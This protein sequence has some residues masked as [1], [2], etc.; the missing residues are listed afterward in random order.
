MVR[1]NAKVGEVDEF[2]KSDGDDSPLYVIP[3]LWEKE[4]EMVAMKKSAMLL[5]LMTLMVFSA[6]M[7]QAQPTGLVTCT[8]TAVPPVV[9]AEGIAE[10]VG[11]V[12]LAC[13][14]TNSAPFAPGVDFLVNISVS[15]NVNVTNNI[16]FGAGTNVSDAVLVINENNCTAPSSVGA[17]YTSCGAP[18]AQ[19]Q[20]PQFGVLAAN[21]RLEWNKTA[22]PVPGAARP[23][24][25][26]N[27]QVTTVRIT[28][29]RGN[30]SQLGVPDAATFPSTQI[31]AFVSIT[32]PTTISVTNN[33]LNVAVPILGL[34][35]TPGKIVTGLQCLDTTTA[36]S[37]KLTEGF[38]TAFKT[39][40]VPTYQPGN[41]QWE[42]G[43]YAPGSNNGGGASQGTRFLI[44]FF[45]IP[46]GVK[47]TVP[48]AINN[49]TA[50]LD[51]DALWIVQVAGADSNGAGGAMTSASDTLT[52]GLSGGF[53]SVTYEVIDDDPFRLESITI[54]IGVS[55]VADTTNDLPAIGTGQVSASF[56]PLSTIVVASN[57][58]PEPRFLDNT[59]DPDTFVSIIRC[60]TTL[61]FPFV[62]NQA[63][64]D[65]GMAIS[66]TSQ[67]WLG[68]DP[69]AG[70]C[71]IHYHGA[72]T[73]GGAA[74]APQTSTV[75]AGGEQLIFTLS[76]GNALQNIA[77]APEFQ[78]YVIAVCEFQYGHGFAFITDGFGGIP[79]LAQGYLALVIPVDDSGERVPGVPNLHRLGE[80][81]SH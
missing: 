59:G 29:M 30:A 26:P 51:G 9:R 60:T 80:S 47:V 44:R 58:A 50:A 43:Y 31:T 14:T 34:I 70:T 21:N 11:D 1:D 33:V 41:T 56:A 37:L 67:D 62:T 77:G 3:I 38:A 78:G 20:D 16:N 39:L 17:T 81:L 42:S 13:V 49:G 12:V 64:F 53:G 72:T 48:K 22:F 68:T 25:D 4:S 71:D 76:G 45:N 73:G 35:V 6:G 24:F 75:I 8:A 63:G 61:L 7:A 55:W 65:T 27:P 2:S 10:L 69:Q 66:N 40:G 32:G 23:G 74:P 18:Y 57:A 52:V 28:S 15:L 36:T 54:P 5:A 79:A 46:Q 19:Y